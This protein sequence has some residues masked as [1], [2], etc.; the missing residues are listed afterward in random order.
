MI[1]KLQ[2][3]LLCALAISIAAPQPMLAQDD[4]MDAIDRIVVTTMKREED[5]QDVPVPVTVIGGEYLEIAAPQN[6]LDATGLA[7][8]VFIGQQTA[9]PGIGAIYSRGQGYADVEKTQSPAFGV[10][11]DGIAFGT[12]TGQLTDLFDVAQIEINRGPQGLLYGKNTTAGVIDIKRTRPTAEPGVRAQFTYGSFDEYAAKVVANTGEFLDGLA[13]LKL[14]AQ[15]READGFFDNLY[16]GST[17][18]DVEQLLLTA[19]LQLNLHE[20]LSVYIVFD[21][22]K[23][24]S[25]TPPVQ[26]EN[27]L[28]NPTVPGANSLSAHDTLADIEQPTEYDTTRVSANVEW[29]TILG[30]VSSVTGYI[31]AGDDVIQDFDS[32]CFSDVRG[33]GCPFN[34]NP[35]FPFAS[36]HTNRMQQ[37]RQ[38][39]QELR[40]A[41]EITERIRT[42]VGAYY[43]DS[44]IQLVQFTDNNFEAGIPGLGVPAGVL[45][46]VVNVQDSRLDTESTALFANVEVDILD[47][48]TVSAGARYISED[49]E[50]RSLFFDTTKAGP[51]TPGS[52]TAVTVPEFEDNA[53]FNDVISRV[54]IDWLVAENHLLYASRSEGFRSGGFSIRATLS[55]TVPGQNNFSNGERFNTF[56]PE[57]VE[58]YEVGSK[59][60]FLDGDLIVNI[61]GFY[62]ELE[63]YQ[64]GF[65]VVTP[66]GPRGTNTYVNNYDEVS[67][68]GAEIEIQAQIPWVEGLAL[69]LSGGYQDIEIDKAQIDAKRVPVGPNQTPGF[70]SQG[71]VD[72]SSTPLSRTP[73]WNYTVSL[74]YDGQLGNGMGIGGQITWRELDDFALANLGSIPDIEDGYGVLD[75]SLYFQVTENVRLG[76]FGRNLTDEEYRAN[77]LPSVGFQSFARPRTF[78]GQVTVEF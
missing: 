33:L 22:M 14:G 47:N 51:L 15:Y 60:T 1:S 71:T 65:V 27:T 73:D 26:A 77:A 6:L 17:V 44:A 3:A 41:T 42:I 61:N 21:H 18:G 39:T 12:N 70:A 19:G 5:V 24:E 59:N 32:T 46:G 20:D 30:T 43:Y 7:P 40:L 13:A 2:W 68:W 23:D 74:L 38:F 10:M 62:Q 16:D 75:A 9:G 55:E 50:I 69:N 57:S 52:I 54:A 78:F 63:G 53:S 34:P 8:N 29:E 31:S 66:G 64:A 28:S 76:V 72:F 25:E 4:D 56:L 36:L 49:F 35:R 58:T 11:V 37:Y 48:L 67:G 45:A